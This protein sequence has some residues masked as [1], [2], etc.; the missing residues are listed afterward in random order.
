MASGTGKTVPVFRSGILRNV[1]GNRDIDQLFCDDF[2]GKI[3]IGMIEDTVRDRNGLKSCRLQMRPFMPGM[4]RLCTGGS[5]SKGT[6]TYVYTMDQFH[7]IEGSPYVYWAGEALRDSFKNDRQLAEFGDAKIGLQTGDTQKFIRLW[8]EIDSCSF[9]VASGKWFPINKGGEYRKWFG[10]NLNVVDWQDNGKNIKTDK[11][12]R[13]KAGLIEKKNSKCWN[14]DY[15][16]RRGITWN[17]ISSSSFSA[18]CYEN[19]IFDI[20]SNGYF[21]FDDSNYLYI[22]G[23]LN[24]KVTQYIADALNPT[25]NLSAGV[26][27]KLPVKDL[28]NQKSEI[29]EEVQRCIDL[30]KTDWN[31]FEVSYE[32]CTHP[33]V[34]RRND[35]MSILLSDKYLEW[36]AKCNQR[37]QE[38]KSN[39]EKINEIFITAYGL[40]NELDS[41]IKDEDVSVKSHDETVTY[42][43]KDR[44][45]S[46]DEE[47]LLAKKRKQQT[48]QEIEEQ[49]EDKKETDCL[50]TKISHLHRGCD[51]YEITSKLFKKMK[52]EKAF[53][54]IP[55][56]CELMNVWK[57]MLLAYELLDEKSL[58]EEK[59][60]EH[61]GE[62]VDFILHLSDEIKNHWEKE[63]TWHENYHKEVRKRIQEKQVKN[64]KEVGHF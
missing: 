59:V 49:I 33:L 26:L 46:L 51:V 5:G 20:A 19:M 40:E 25:M 54:K 15:Y 48:I 58:S 50:L 55:Y 14:E 27:S 60:E 63:K 34:G 21:V 23:L 41:T 2:S 38:L 16:F 17:L 47:Y 62:D 37:F 31:M 8:F 30:A 56:F 35:K 4:P 42:F 29:N 1:G 9:N 36:E 61:W 22:A 6:N 44:E 24:S 39:E 11:L 52:K 10:N 32:F 28:V 12:E 13:L 18:R 7:C 57:A 64:Q 43:Q 53:L 3:V 45:K